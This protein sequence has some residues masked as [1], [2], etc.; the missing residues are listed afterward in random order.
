MPL[1]KL[2]YH[3][4]QSLIQQATY[5]FFLE[6]YTYSP[7]VLHLTSY[8]K[9]PF[10]VGDRSRKLG[11]F[12]CSLDSAWITNDL[13]YPLTC[14]LNP[15]RVI[16]AERCRL[17]LYPFQGVKFHV[18]TFLVKVV[19]CFTLFTIVTYLQSR[20]AEVTDGRVVRAGVSVT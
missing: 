13:F 10:H 8:I 4:T 16:Q 5:L 7:T 2:G 6:Y 17:I 20:M 9:H 12:E 3:Y 11:T 1:N 19:T 18:H 14:T 15:I